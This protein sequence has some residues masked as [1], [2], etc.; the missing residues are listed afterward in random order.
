VDYHVP[1][2]RGWKSKSVQD[3]HGCASH[4]PENL[5]F[6]SVLWDR[7]HP[8]IY[9]SRHQF[10][11]LHGRNE[12]PTLETNTIQSLPL[13]PEQA[14]I[15]RSLSLSSHL[16]QGRPIPGESEDQAAWRSIPKAN[17][18]RSIVSPSSSQFPSQIENNPKFDPRIHSSLHPASESASI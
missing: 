1:R 17:D 8:Y 13:Y 14:F 12:C 7:R 6:T 9:Q 18:M 2:L 10:F 16:T 15:A 3:W 4:L 5:Y 11:W